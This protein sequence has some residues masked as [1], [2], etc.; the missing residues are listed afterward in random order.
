MKKTIILLILI[1]ILTAV[2]PLTVFLEKKEKSP[3]KELV[4]IFNSQSINESE[5]NPL[6]AQ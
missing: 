1:F 4:T 6:Q 5:Y 2:I 3:D